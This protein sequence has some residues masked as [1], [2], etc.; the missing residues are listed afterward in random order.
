MWISII[1]SFILIMLVFF[2]YYRVSKAKWYASEHHNY[3]LAK[4]SKILSNFSKLFSYNGE[5]LPY[6]RA[7]GFFK[8]FVSEDRRVDYYGYEPVRSKALE[9][10]KEYGV[11]LTS[12]GVLLKKQKHERENGQELFVSFKGIWK[13]KHYLSNLVIYYYDTSH[14]NFN[15]KGFVSEENKA[16]NAKNMQQFLQELIDCGYTRDLYKEDNYL[17]ELYSLINKSK[18]NS[19]IHIDPDEWFALKKRTK[20]RTDFSSLDEEVEETVK[21]GRL[22]DGLSTAVVAAN[23]MRLALSS[24]A[25][26]LISQVRNSTGGSGYAAEAYNTVEDK[27]RFNKA[28]VIGGNNAK[29]SADRIVNG[30]EVQTKYYNNSRA[31]VNAAF[32]ESGYRYISKNGSPMQLEVPADQYVQS[33]EFMRKKILRGDIPGVK[34]PNEAF[35]II[36]KGHATYEQAQLITQAFN[37][38]SITH[39]LKSGLIQ[40]TSPAGISVLIVFAHAKWSGATTEEAFKLAAKTGIVHLVI[41]TVMHATTAQL[42]KAALNSQINT[43]LNGSL[44]KTIVNGVPVVVTSI[45]LYGWDTLNYSSGKISK[46]QFKKN[47]IVK[48]GGVGGAMIGASLPFFGPT[49]GAVG[50]GTVTYIALQK[51]MDKIYKD[52]RVI[53]YPVLKEEFMDLMYSVKLADHE[54][55]EIKQM[56]FIKK[57]NRH[58]KNMQKQLSNQLNTRDFA[59]NQIIIPE[60]SKV[61]GKR[62]VITDKEINLLDE[63]FNSC[64]Y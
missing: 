40:S 38:T 25:S 16:L 31:T 53:H 35:R 5:Q 61:I 34:D 54:I 42:T 39:D 63:Y 13:V 20:F 19:Y 45:V 62:K 64:Y 49:V 43:L 41:G 11:L 47:T 14:I 10:F 7:H 51:V 32:D 59:R 4:L 55:D 2:T 18:K 17:E 60:I 46:N 37:V 28:E 33:I 23:S 48:T 22:K 6:G 52:D 57:L 50:F 1:I 15:L 21:S 58:V 9:E 24:K 27:L 56:I 30:T 36:R 44:N 8:S 3:D 29:N 26:N 12:D